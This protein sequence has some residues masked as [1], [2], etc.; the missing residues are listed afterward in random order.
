MKY[1]YNE[2]ATFLTTFFDEIENEVIK[3]IYPDCF[4]SSVKFLHPVIK[5]NNI[6]ED[7]QHFY[8]VYTQKYQNN[9]IKNNKN[10]Y[11]DK[12]KIIKIENIK[13]AENGAKVFEGINPYSSTQD[14][15]LINGQIVNDPNPRLKKEYK[16]IANKK[17][18]QAM[19]FGFIF[20]A[21]LRQP[22]REQDKTS[23]MAQIMAMQLTKEPE[24]EWKFFEVE[25]GK[26]IYKK[27]T[28]QELVQMSLQAKTLTLNA[29]KAESSVLKDL[30]Q[31]DDLT[32]YN[33][34]ERFKKYLENK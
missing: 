2:N 1:I 13:D 20:K 28:L 21:N 10:M 19:D 24:C 8:T 31:L 6:I 15:Y 4:I 23:M 16:E 27:L 26:H 22:C 34:D 14:L 9:E 33:I 32:T 25:T 11:I 3:S 18:H 5:N 29:M 7:E 17:K 12:N 30:E